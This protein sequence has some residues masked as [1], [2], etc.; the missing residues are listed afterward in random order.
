MSLDK[1]NIFALWSLIRCTILYNFV[2]NK[3]RQKY[4]K[5]QQWYVVLLNYNTEFRN[6]TMVK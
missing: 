3:V 2:K 4:I 1:E 6:K 5:N